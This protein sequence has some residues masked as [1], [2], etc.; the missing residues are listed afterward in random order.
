MKVM[1]GND[2]AQNFS[3]R[4]EPFNIPA[5]KAGLWNSITIL[6]DDT[7]VALTSTNGW[8]NGAMEVWMIKG[9]LKK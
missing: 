4:T 5:G 3:G 6:K 8:G 1:V 7:I 9:R 2:L